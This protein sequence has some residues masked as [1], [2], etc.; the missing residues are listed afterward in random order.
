[1]LLIQLIVS[2]LPEERIYSEHAT[3]MSLLV[4]PKVVCHLIVV[5]TTI[6]YRI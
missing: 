2:K 5:S 1:M 4:S 3:E 6:F